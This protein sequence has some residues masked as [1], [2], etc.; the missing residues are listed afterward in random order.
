MSVSDRL[1]RLLVRLLPEEF[2]AGYARELAVTFKAEARE[3]RASGRWRALGRLWVATVGDILRIAPAEHLDILWRD[4]RYAL[5]AMAARPLL[6]GTAVATLAIGLGANVAMFSVVDAVLLRPLPY[7]APSELAIVRETAAGGDPSNMGY[8]TFLDLRDRARTFRAMAAASMSI[9]TLTGDGRDAER[10]NAM[11]VSATYFDVIGVSPAIGR[12]FTDAE[13]RPG[14]ARRVVI[15]ADSL[16]RRRYGADPGI[17]GRPIVVGGTPFTVVGVM[18]RGFEDLV[19]DRLYDGAEFWVPLGYDPAAS[20]AC[21]TCRHLRVFGR[22]APGV[23]AADAAR[24]LG[25]II[26]SAAEAH[27]REYDKPGIVVASLGDF[28][29]GPVRTTMLVLWAGVGVLLL[30]ACGNVANLL[31]LRASERRQEVAVRTALGVTTGRL[32]RQLVTESLLLALAGGVA[33]ILPAWAAIRLLTRLGPDTVPRLATASL[34]ARAVAAGLALVVVSGVLFGLA[35]LRQV[36]RRDVAADMHGAGRRTAGAATWRLRAA[37]VGGNVAM[38]VL[39][40]VGAGLLV[41]T[42]TGLLAVEPGLDPSRVMTMSVSLTGDVLRG[43]ENRPAIAAATRFYDELLERT[44][45]LPGVE[46][47]SAV[48]TLPIGSGIDG[49]GLHFVGRPEENPEASPYG[50]RFV[51]VPGF[52]EAMRIPVVAGRALARTDGQD[53][54]LVVVVNRRM[55]A[56]IYPGESAIGHQLRLG[57]PD[58]PP[59]TIVGV[60]GDVRHHGLDEEVGYQF[61]VPQAQWPWAEPGLT[62]VVRTAGDPAGVVGPVREIARAIR[63]AGID[64]APPVTDVAGY[65]DVVASS[66]GTRPFAA[67]LLAAYAAAALLLAG[68]GLYGALGVL[69]GQRQR[70]IGV[71]L[72]L[73]AGA[74]AIQRMIFVEGLRPVLGG[75]VLG[76]AAAAAASGVLGSL[77]YGVEALD[78]PTFVISAVVLLLVAA[79]ACALPA[80]R[81]ARIDPATTLRAE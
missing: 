24:D 11:R 2:R 43:D 45:A 79:T 67:W 60:V 42:L 15:L 5:R 1:F 70:E 73:G 7:R 63:V 59:R 62:L 23:T 69:V 65:E 34:D 13:D 48:T 72:A 27:P 16:W 19:A 58:G 35:P 46:A 9:A 21:R 3:A 14:A 39:L 4:V 30:V 18:P 17:V 52:I 22:L 10:V 37:L 6:T 50:D 44:R 31:L 8:L 61:Y 56:E 78:G 74:S 66:L 77:L 76:L 53:A 55:A 40:L 71:R 12:A 26:A 28:F 47:A 29:L 81:A 68:V 80:W 33:G 51:V 32:A 54:P 64:P 36:V 38:A 57:D 49:Y 20:F 25:G 75:L 41:R